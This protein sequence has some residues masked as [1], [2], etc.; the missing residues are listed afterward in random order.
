MTDPFEASIGLKLPKLSADIVTI[1]H[2]HADHNNLAAVS[3]PSSQRA[4][5]FAIT[6][7]GE[8]EVAGVSIFGFPSFHDNQQGRER[9][10]NTIYVI[11]L[12]GIRLVHLGDLGHPIGEKLLEAVN[13]AEILMIPV[14]GA[15]TIDAQQAAAEVKKIQPQITIPMHY[16]LPGLKYDLA[17]VEKFLEQVGDETV[18]PQDKLVIS[19]DKLPEENETVVLNAR[20]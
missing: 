12:D 13:G 8:Y 10:E 17:P 15:F 16:G 14:G 4:K 2:Q 5:P 20:S 3:G 6:G 7:P 11:Q 9:G 1:S 19:H 18:K